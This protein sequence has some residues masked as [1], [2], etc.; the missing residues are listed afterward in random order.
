MGFISV[1]PAL[2]ID[3]KSLVYNLVQ[4]SAIS[5]TISLGL[6]EH[7]NIDI[8]SLD[9]LII[10]KA[11]HYEVE[12]LFDLYNRGVKCEEKIGIPRMTSKGETEESQ[13]KILSVSIDGKEENITLEKNVSLREGIMDR[14][15]GLL[16]L[17]IHGIYED[18]HLDWF[19]CRVSFPYR[20]DILLRIKYRSNYSHGVFT[21]ALY[22]VGT[23][24][25]RTGSIGK[26]KFKVDSSEIGGTKNVTAGL[27]RVPITPN[28]FQKSIVVFGN[29]YCDIHGNVKPYVQEENDVFVDMSKNLISYSIKSLGSRDSAFFRIVVPDWD[30]CVKWIEQDG[31]QFMLITGASPC[32]I[33]SKRKR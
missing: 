28:D 33:P 12:A 18:Y 24:V 4:Q 32:P 16:G 11:T 26:A 30:N 25:F 21:E 9:V 6:I 31:N 1:H 27:Y 29:K 10:L 8:D 15:L 5:G 13:F 17:R 14:K 23:G 2:S 19:T 22:F 3:K 7:R 20:K